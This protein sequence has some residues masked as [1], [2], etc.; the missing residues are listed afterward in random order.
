MPR[1]TVRTLRL[2]AV[3]TSRGAEIV[4]LWASCMRQ[5]EFDIFVLAVI[6]FE[7]LFI[8]RSRF[9]DLVRHV[10]AFEAA[11]NDALSAISAAVGMVTHDKTFIDLIHY[12]QFDRVRRT[13][14]D[15]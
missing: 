2:G 7:G 5:E 8:R 14:F 4:G 11:G 13:I 6:D 9:P 3:A 1:M 15:A 10:H 12:D